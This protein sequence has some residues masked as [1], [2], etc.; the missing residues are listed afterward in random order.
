MNDHKADL[1]RLYDFMCGMAVWRPAG[2]PPNLQATATTS[3]TNFGE[4]SPTSVRKGTPLAPVPVLLK[5]RPVH[6]LG[7]AGDAI[8][9]GPAFQ[10]QPDLFSSW[11]HQLQASWPGRSIAQLLSC[12]AEQSF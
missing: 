5:E 1:Y 6:V 8:A 11:P 2:S 12:M 4:G 7:R 9:S 10:R 3:A